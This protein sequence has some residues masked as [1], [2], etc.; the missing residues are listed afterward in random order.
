MATKILHQGDPPS[1]LVKKYF[2]LVG[3]LLGS[4]PNIKKK[5]NAM[6]N[7]QNW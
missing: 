6:P 1:I 2:F 7:E 5:T 4:V 3:I